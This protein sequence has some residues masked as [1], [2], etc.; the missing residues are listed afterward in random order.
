MVDEFFREQ[1]RRRQQT[2]ADPN[3]AKA[4]AIEMRQHRNSYREIAATLGIGET[5]ARL[6]CDP[7]A[8]D[9]DRQRR[10]A[11][12]YDD[13]PKGRDKRRA[14]RSAPL[15][16]VWNYLDRCTDETN[17]DYEHIAEQCGASVEQVCKV[18]RKFCRRVYGY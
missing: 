1:Q 18:Y 11:K 6:W 4:R 9:R 16:R 8:A 13:W 7:D 5:T 12:Y 2:F 15:H 10:R 14:E 3:A 17:L